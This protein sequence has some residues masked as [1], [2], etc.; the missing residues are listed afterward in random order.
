VIRSGDSRSG[1]ANLVRSL[2]T[3]ETETPL[4]LPR[5]IDWVNWL[6]TTGS[7]E[8]VKQPEWIT[9]LASACAG[10]PGQQSKE[11]I[12]SLV[13]SDPEWF[14]VIWRIA[15]RVGRYP[16]TG[17][18][19]HQDAVDLVA[20]LAASPLPGEGWPGALLDALNAG[21]RYERPPE[22]AAVIDVIRVMLGGQ[23]E[24]FPTGLEHHYYTMYIDAF[25]R[26]L[27]LEALRS[28]RIRVERHFLGYACRDD[29]LSPAAAYLLQA[30]AADANTVSEVLDFIKAGSITKLY[31]SRLLDF[32]FWQNMLSLEPGLAGHFSVGRL[33]RIRE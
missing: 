19:S 12:Q 31:A 9:A 8:Q 28:E 15:R 3:R 18:I 4:C 29:A 24:E 25:G 22:F 16:M 32:E 11:G 14:I 20:R 6:Y 26:I 30:L 17:K 1:Q 13:R 27:A 33:T 5:A 7:A 21:S 10:S 2:L 23:P